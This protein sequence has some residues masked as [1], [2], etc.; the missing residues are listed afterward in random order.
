MERMCLNN[1]SCRSFL[2]DDTQ[3]QRCW[4][5]YCQMCPEAYMCNR[6]IRD[7][8]KISQYC[9][10]ACD[11]LCYQ[12]GRGIEVCRFS[13]ETCYMCKDGY[14]PSKTT[15]GRCTYS[16]CQT[17]TDATRCETCKT[18]Y[19]GEQCNST[20]S[21]GCLNSTCNI[22]DGSCECKD[23][24][25]G[26]KC[27]L[28]CSSGCQNNTCHKQDGSCVCKEGYFGKQ[29][30]QECAY[31]CVSS[32]VGMNQTLC[33]HITGECT[34]CKT[35]FFGRLCDSRCNL[36]CSARECEQMTGTCLACPLNKTFGGA[37]ENQC[38]NSCDQNKCYAKDGNCSLGCILNHYG[39][40]CEFSC[41]TNCKPME[42]WVV[43]DAN[44]TCLGGCVDGYSGD[45]CLTGEK[46]ALKY[47]KQNTNIEICL[48]Y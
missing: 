19:W 10:M 29:C 37:C 25:W 2:F 26:E 23:G 18:G 6:C 11:D 13:N 20:C 16:G 31:T 33:N 3:C 34:H 42:N 35:G 12:Y 47:I 22:G 30:Q 43:C 28:T 27:N 36:N 32:S 44:G 14:Y 41:S 5:P 17:C 46:R 48:V 39:P 21:I 8:D 45:K 15:C 4:Y 1:Q 7:S 24:Y 9:D 40:R 38:S